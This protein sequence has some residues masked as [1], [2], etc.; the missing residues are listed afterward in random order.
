MAPVFRIRSKLR[1]WGTILIDIIDLGLESRLL[2]FTKK[3]NPINVK[4]RDQYIY[5]VSKNVIYVLL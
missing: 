1:L 2:L 5:K 4:G 3:A